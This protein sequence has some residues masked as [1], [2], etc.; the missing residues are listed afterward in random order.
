M[1]QARG[2]KTEGVTIALLALLLTP[3]SSSRHIES[4]SP[5]GPALGLNATN[6]EVG[7]L[8]T[9]VLVPNGPGAWV[10]D[11][12]WHE[13]VFTLRNLSDKTVTIERIRLVDPRGLYIDPSVNPLQLE[14]TSDA[15]AAQYKDAAVAVAPAVIGGVALIGAG[16]AIGVIAPPTLLIAVPAYGIYK[17]QKAHRTAQER[18][19]L[20]RELNRQL[21]SFTLA[22]QSTVSGSLFFPIVPNPRALTVDYRIGS[23]MKELALAIPPPGG[24]P[25]AG[26]AASPVAT[27]ESP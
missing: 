10:K 19:E 6:E 23:E 1:K 27:V 3:C 4:P 9:Y 17:V 7:L 18:E 26:S 25:L 14:K 13:Y 16:A 8:L 15:L 2:A 20:E 5:P 21:P 22:G 12:Q 11:A 24:L